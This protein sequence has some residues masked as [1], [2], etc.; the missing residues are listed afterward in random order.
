MKLVLAGSDGVNMVELSTDP[1]GDLLISSPAGVSTPPPPCTLDNPNRARCPAGSISKVRAAF[2]A[3]DDS[4]EVTAAVRVPIWASGG[5]GNDRLAGGARGD[6]LRGDGG[7]DELTG[8]GGADGLI[9]GSG[10]DSCAGGSG[11]RD[12]ASGCETVEGVP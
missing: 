2:L 10:K 1:A 7:T 3:G 9:G 8:H 4:L 5:N 6:R 12:W 11:H